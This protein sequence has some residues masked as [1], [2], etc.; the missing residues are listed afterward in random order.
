MKTMIGVAGGSFD[1]VHRGHVATLCA[2]LARLPFREIRVPPAA[3]SP[4]KPEP[5]AD[6]HR[7][8][9]LRLALRGKAGLVLD[10]REL[11]R[12]PPS[13]TI[14]TLRAI[15]ADVGPDTPLVFILGIDRLLELPRWKD[16]QALTAQAHLLVASRPGVAPAFSPA[17]ADWLK[18]VRTAEGELLQSMPQGLVLFLDTQPWPVARREIRRALAAGKPVGDELDPAVQDYI[19]RHHLYQQHGETTAQ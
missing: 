5:T 19:Q 18:S 3:R 6:I 16:W 1:P 15:R 2:L 12:P 4:L 8:A 14:D 10:E 11:H 17:L 9:M 13:Y 7:L